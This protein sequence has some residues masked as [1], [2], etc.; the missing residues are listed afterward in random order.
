MSQIVAREQSGGGAGAVVATVGCSVLGFMMAGPVGAVIG[1]G[2]AIAA[3]SATK[4]SDQRLPLGI[5]NLC[6]PQDQI[7]K[8]SG[9]TYFTVEI[10]DANG[11]TWKVLRRYNDF[12]AFR[13]ALRRYRVHHYFPGKLW[14]GC[15][16][17]RLEARRRSLEL[18]AQH[19]ML[20]HFANGVPRQL[21]NEFDLFLRRGQGSITTP[22][23]FAPAITDAGGT[24]A[25]EVPPGVVAGQELTVR[26]PDGSSFR[27]TVPQGMGP[28]SILQVQPQGRQQASISDATASMKDQTDGASEPRKTMLS[29]SVPDGVSSGQTL[30]V[31]VPD[32]RELTVVVPPGAPKELLSVMGQEDANH[33]TG[34]SDSDE[35][36]QIQVPPGIEAGQIVNIQVP[37]GRQLPVM[38]S[39]GCAL[40]KLISKVRDHRGESAS[41]EVSASSKVGHLTVSEGQDSDARQV[42]GRLSSK[43][44][45][46]LLSVLD[47]RRNSHAL[48]LAAAA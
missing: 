45:E 2:L 29:I 9:I 16:G 38:E 5:S 31:Q 3:A 36:F 15:E 10:Q 33:S 24:F 44:T 21:Q 48:P 37:D 28:G 22:S 7:V 39:D 42:I 6:L 26:S 11:S 14:L 17:P 41:P 32:G 46:M 40:W 8:R 43:E 18:W 12:N 20:R 25:I 34:P 35:V 30:A 47:Y 27:I 19:V 23:G 4:R 13:R 1:G